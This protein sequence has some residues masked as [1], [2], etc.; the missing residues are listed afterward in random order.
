[1]FIIAILINLLLKSSATIEFFVAMINGLQIVVHI[2]I[3][4]ILMPGNVS[5]FLSLL[6]PIVM[7]DFLDG[8]EGTSYDPN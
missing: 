1:M 6:Q 7:F 2:P 8:L 5:M 4:R 3:L